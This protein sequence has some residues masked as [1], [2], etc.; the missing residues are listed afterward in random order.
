MRDAAARSRGG[1]SRSLPS[2]AC[3][4]F[5]VSLPTA[6]SPSFFLIHS[7]SPPAFS[8]RE[9]AGAAVGE[10]DGMESRRS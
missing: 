8:R 3:F 7:P 4:P 10:F 6:L 9:R 5:A 1:E 2:F